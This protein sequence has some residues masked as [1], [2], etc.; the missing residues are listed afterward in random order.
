MATA[1]AISTTAFAQNEI[2]RLVEEFSTVGW[3]N[4]TSAVERD[5]KTHRIIKTVKTLETSGNNIGAL[6]NAFENEAHSGNFSKKKEDNYLKHEYTK[7]QLDSV[8][9]KLEDMDDDWGD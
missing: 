7:E 3:S 2:D 1:L 5:P 8:V 4:F 6:K 9:R